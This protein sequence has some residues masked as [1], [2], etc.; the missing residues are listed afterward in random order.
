M[1]MGKKVLS[2]FIIGLLILTLLPAG[3]STLQTVK[4]PNTIM[5]NE[6]IFY[7]SQPIISEKDGFCEITLAG[8]TTHIIEPQKPVLPISVKTYQIPFRSTNIQVT[9]TPKTIKTMTL[10]KEVIPGLTRLTSG[11]NTPIVYEKDP[12]VYKSTMFYPSTWYSYDLGA[13]RNDNDVQMTFVK[14]ICYPVRYSPLNNQIEY[15]DDFTITISYDAPDSPPQSSPVSYDMVIIAPKKFESTLKPLLD[16]KNSKGI[17][18]LFKSL[19]DIIKEYTGAD[20]PEQVKYFIKDAFD[21]WNIT[22]VLL[23]GGLKSHIYAKDKDTRSAGW[24]AWWLPVRYVNIPYEDDEGCLCDLYYGC[25][26]T[27]NGSFDNWD[28]N[29]DGVYAAWGAPGASKDTFDLYPEVYVG[30]L[31]VANTLELRRQVNKIITY[32][33]TGPASKDW[34]TTF[35]GIGGKTG[36]MYEGKPDGEWLCDLA[37]NYTKLAIPTLTLLPIYSTNRIRGGPVP[38]KKGIST[39]ITQGA[40]FVDMEGH[41]SPAGWDT[42]WYNG[43][44]PIDWIGGLGLQDFWRIQNGKKLPVIIVGGCHNAMYNISM[45]A[46]MKDKEGTSYFVYGYKVPYCFCWGLMLKATGGPIAITGSTGYG[47]GYNDHPISLSAELETNFFYQ[48][49][50][51]TTHMGQAHGQAIQKFLAEE[52]IGQTEA[53]VI[54]DWAVLG[55]PSL[56]FGGYS[57]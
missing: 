45:I 11:T 21:T 16:E 1:N 14:V 57:S 43:T 27:A 26:Y 6:S 42:I 4:K 9:C 5:K 44:Y 40:G 13:G 22:Y 54:T 52:D 12:T 41:G 35:V 56:L 20:Q 31:P 53:F 18:T 48:I 36:D 17:V 25:L 19:E 24:K 55:D 51:G 28:S 38:D 46:G 34:Y 2:L 29:G 15:T 37:Y 30:R 32:E 39:A 47:V 3:S 7:L 10:T 23:A 50:Q 8:T 49:G 33:R